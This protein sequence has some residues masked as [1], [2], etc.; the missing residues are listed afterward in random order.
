MKSGATLSRFLVAMLQFF[1]LEA[2]ALPLQERQRGGFFV[3]RGGM[4]QGLARQILN[5]ET[6]VRFPVPL[7]IT[8]DYYRALPRCMEK[9]S[10]IVR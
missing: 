3:L 8:F 9:T 4:V 6:R 2:D 10:A 1:R 5:L 7:P